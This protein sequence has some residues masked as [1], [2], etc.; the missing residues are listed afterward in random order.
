MKKLLVAAVATL[1]LSAFAD[2]QLGDLSKSDV[3]KVGNEFAVNFAHTTVSAPETSGLWG[4]EV[5]V[6]GGATK[7]PGLEKV[8][9]ASGGDGKDFKSIYHGGLMA[10]VHLPLEIFLEATAL[11]KREISDVNVK[12]GSFGIGWNAG[13][14]FNLPLDL[15]VGVNRSR[16]DISF[17]QDADA[18][19]SIPES[20]IKVK[21]Q[22]TIAWVG[23]SK[24]FLVFTPYVK[25]GMARSEADVKTD[26][27]G[28]FNYTAKMKE[29][30]DKNG[31]YFAF[32]AN[33]QLLFLK[34]GAEIAQQNGVKNATG[35][36]SFDF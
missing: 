26:A 21:T 30:V 24:T 20:N 33:L 25:V 8:V 11:P 16:A 29:T 28:I 5:G 34:F 23:V 9:D 3:Q 10:R 1:S 31:G 7:S 36:V 12:S 27:T 17:H 4:V 2:I 14:F 22:N 19:N 35:K 32:G 15:S 6:V 13:G 18:A